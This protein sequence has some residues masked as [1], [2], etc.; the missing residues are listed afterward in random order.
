MLSARLGPRTSRVT[1]LAYLV[2]CSAA[3]PAE[4]PPP[5]TNTGRSTIAGASDTAA[6]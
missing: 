2:R 3:W 5:T 1:C 6:P 4:L